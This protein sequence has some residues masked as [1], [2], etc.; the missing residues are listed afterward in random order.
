MVEQEDRMIFIPELVAKLR[1]E[2]VRQAG[3]FMPN[4]G[5]TFD[6]AMTTWNSDGAPKGD[7]FEEDIFKTFRKVQ[8]DIRAGE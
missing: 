8:E 7:S 4:P 6:D 2:F 1:K 3:R 5:A